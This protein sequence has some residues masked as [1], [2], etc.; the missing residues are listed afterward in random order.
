[1]RSITHMNVQ[2]VQSDEMIVLDEIRTAMSF[3]RRLLL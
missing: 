1:M 2:L 3:R